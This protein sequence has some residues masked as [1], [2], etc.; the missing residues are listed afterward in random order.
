MLVSSC[1]ICLNSNQSDLVELFSY[2][3]KSNYAIKLNFCA[4]VE[5]CKENFH[6]RQ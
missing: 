6:L 4:G 1:R 3:E 2:D 5:V